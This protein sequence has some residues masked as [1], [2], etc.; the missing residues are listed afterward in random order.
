MALKRHPQFGDVPY[1]IPFLRISY[2]KP[3]ILQRAV[4]STSL[5]PPKIV[6]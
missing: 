5:P 3:Q 1:K 6:H 4:R 2:Y